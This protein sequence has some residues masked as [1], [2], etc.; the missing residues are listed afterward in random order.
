MAKIDNKGKCK[1]FD[2]QMIDFSCLP[3]ISVLCTGS[4]YKERK[5]SLVNWTFT[6]LYR[7]S[8]ET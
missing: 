7:F 5:E 1:P 8:T 2:N 3:M 6:R 4:G